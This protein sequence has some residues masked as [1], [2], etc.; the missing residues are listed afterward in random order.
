[1]S[2]KVRQTEEGLD[3][4]KTGHDTLTAHMNTMNRELASVKAEQDTLTS[5]VDTIN[6]EFASVKTGQ[7]TLTVHMNTMNRKLTSVQAKQNDLALQNQQGN[8][9]HAQDLVTT[10]GMLSVFSEVTVHA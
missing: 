9:S 10:E 1:M 5:N 8:Y 4:L 7:D 2:S 3:S 6:R